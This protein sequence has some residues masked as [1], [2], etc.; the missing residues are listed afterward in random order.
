M[1]MDPKQ[2]QKVVEAA[3]KNIALPLI[4]QHELVEIKYRG[5]ISSILNQDLFESLDDGLEKKPFLLPET[6][7]YTIVT[8]IRIVVECASA[9]CFTFR[10][11]FEH[12][13]D[14]AQGIRVWKFDRPLL[15]Q[16]GT[17]WSAAFTGDLSEDAK[18]PY[19]NERGLSIRLLG[20]EVTEA[21]GTDLFAALEAT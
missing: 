12:V 15:L 7:A 10:T 1:T 6:Q 16:P 9:L 20:F 19:R 5:P 11:T 21:A 3:R 14:T 4:E 18:D 8:A 13:N 17:K 2:V